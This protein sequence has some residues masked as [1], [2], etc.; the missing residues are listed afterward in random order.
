MLEWFWILP[1]ISRRRRGHGAGN[2]PGMASLF[3]E[4]II[5]QMQAE[6]MPVAR[7]QNGD[8]GTFEDWLNLYSHV[9][10]TTL[11]LAAVELVWG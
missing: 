7:N 11:G 5:S 10:G 2:S 6:G 3:T 4:R 1:S 8:S 9:G